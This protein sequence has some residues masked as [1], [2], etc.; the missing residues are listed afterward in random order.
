MTPSTT[1][2][3]GRLWSSCTGQRVD[4]GPQDDGAPGPAAVEGEDASGLGGPQQLRD[5]Q[6]AHVVADQLG[7]GHLGEAQLGLAVHRPA[8]IDHLVEDAVGR[9]RPEEVAHVARAR[10]SR[11]IWVTWISSVPA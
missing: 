3:A 2:C 4:V 6:A 1:E 9:G 11:A 7:R 8:Q 10:R 5:T